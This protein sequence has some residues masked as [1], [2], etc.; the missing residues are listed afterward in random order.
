MM[1]SPIIVEV[2]VT[3][4]H[5]VGN[6]TSNGNMKVLLSMNLLAK[7]KNID[8]NITLSFL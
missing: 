3:M 8:L 7:L 5:A 4:T 6:A 2:V 1:E